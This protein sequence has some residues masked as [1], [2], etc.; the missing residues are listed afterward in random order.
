MMALSIKLY[1]KEKNIYTLLSRGFSRY[2]SVA[3]IIRCIFAEITKCTN[4]NC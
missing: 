3:D 2:S 4:E 1:R